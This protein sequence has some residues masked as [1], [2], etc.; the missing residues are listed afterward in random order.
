ML[1]SVTVAGQR[2]VHPTPPASSDPFGAKPGPVVLR[3]NNLITVFRDGLGIFSQTSG[4][5]P[6]FHNY[7]SIPSVAAPGQVASEAGATTGTP[8]IVGYRLG[9]G[10]VVD[11]RLIGFG[12]SLAH[13]VNAQELTN[14]LWRLLSR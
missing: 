8:S 10:I 2:A 4:A 11:I 12:S 7:Q 6:G 14:S 5:F 9:R 3:S 1:R 13:N